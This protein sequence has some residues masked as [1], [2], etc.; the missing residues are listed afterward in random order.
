MEVCALLTECYSSSSCHFCWWKD[1]V[2][3]T[4]T[5]GKCHYSW[6]RGEPRI[7]RDRNRK[8]LP[9]HVGIATVWNSDRLSELRCF[10]LPLE[11]TCRR[12][13]TV[14]TCTDA[15]ICQWDWVWGIC[16]LK[17]PIRLARSRL[18]WDDTGKRQTNWNEAGHDRYV[19]LRFFMVASSMGFYGLSGNL[20]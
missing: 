1:V 11:I 18:Q 12:P 3:K 4:C 16:Q 15:F 7:G 13:A 9:I 8:Y 17:Q 14:R 10:S 5:V 20:K 6:H 19:A 2:S